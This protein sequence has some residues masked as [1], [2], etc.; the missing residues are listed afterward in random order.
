MSHRGLL[1]LLVLA[2]A[3]AS[4]AQTSTATLQG[5]VT[6][7]SGA[8][9]PGG[10]ILI[11]NVNTGTT[12]E[13]ASQSDGTYVVPFLL[14]GDYSLNV[15]KQGFRRFSQDRIR[16]NVGQTAVVDVRLV[17]GDIATTVEVSA[18]AAPLQTADSTVQTSISN[19]SITDLPLNGRLVLNLVA[20]VPG[21][22]TG[23]SSA[24]GQNDNYTPMI[25]G[26]RMMTS[27]AF[28][29][30]APLSVADPTG[31]ARV[32]GGLPPSPDAVEE[33]TVQVNGL[34]AE[35]GRSG[36]GV[37]NI[38][39]RAGTNDLHGTARYFHRNSVFDANNFFANRNSV[40]LA[41]F[42]RHQYGFSVGGPVHIP[43]VYSGRNRTF[44]FVDDEFT[45]ERSPRDVTTTL[46][47]DPWKQ[48]DFSGLLNFRGAPITIFD[49][50]T[51]RQTASGVWTRE[52]FPGNR[53]PVSRI[54]PISAK[55]I[56]YWPSPNRPSSNQFIP[57]N[58]WFNS[59][60][61]VVN[62]SNLTV[63]AD[64]NFTGSWRTYV[65]YN[66]SRYT[67]DPLQLVGGGPADSSS[68]NIRP[69]QNAVWDNTFILNPSTTMNVRLNGT[70]WQY[71]LYPTTMGFDSNSL[72]FPSYLRQE[73]LA[74]WPHFPGIGVSGV[75]GRGGGGG[76]DWFSNSVNLAGSV[77]K[78]RGRHTIKTG[79]EYRKFFLNFY[80]PG[81]PNGNFSFSD[82]WTRG[83][84]LSF[85][86][87][88]GFGFAT[89]LLGTP[90]GGSQNTVPK[91]ALASSYWAGFIQDDIRV[92]SKLTLNLGL[93][94]DMDT[95]RTE[96]YNRMSYYDLSA[97]S[98]IASQ[99][100][101]FPNLVGV[102]RYVDENNRRQTPSITDQ[103]AP[104]F[105]FAYQVNTK[106]VVRGGYAIMYDASPMQ[107]ANHNAG[108]EGFRLSNSMITTL[109]GG[110]TPAGTLS[111]PFPF[112]FLSPGRDPSF[113]LGFD[114]GDS[115]IP[116]W[117][118]PMVQQWN[119]NIQ[120]ELPGQMVV[121]VAYIANAGHQLQNG[122]TTPYNQLTTNYL[123]LGPQLRQQVPNPFYGVI[124]DQRS[125][126]SRPTVEYGQLLR[127][128]PQLTGLNLQWRP[129]GNSIY[130]AATIRAERRFSN[131]FAFMLAYTG[132][133]LISDSEASGFFTS[134]GQ[135]AAQDT[136][137][138]RAER[139]VSVEDIAHRV[140][141][142]GDYQLP[143]GRGKSLLSRS[144][145]IVQALIGNWQLNGIYTLQSGQ[146][147]N[148]LQPTNQMGI[149][150][151]RQRPSNNG[152]PASYTSG[153]TNDR[154][155]QWFD[156][157][158]FSI[159]PAF[160]L[161]TAPRTLT[162]V[163][164]PGRNNVDAS[165]FK[166]F[167]IL[168]DGRL[169]AQFRVEA[170]NAFN[171]AQFNRANATIGIAATGNITSVAVNP[172]QL[173]LGLKLIF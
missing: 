117:R 165:I 131:G 79:M 159:T 173:Q 36:G 64:H 59:G 89:F 127:P 154:I 16:L 33:F 38:A 90:T 160:Q 23:V 41:S 81:N 44:F 170:F 3:G 162:N 43:G 118:S 83:N 2:L 65:R 17:I 57:Q 106:T 67:I 22:Y 73:S 29:D 39:T 151:A 138:R 109:D 97:P 63:R 161:G 72:G 163:R 31:G 10:K 75:A 167:P 34:P 95:V 122:D 150:N 124:T 146:P 96:R 169:N 48:G 78:I 168:R 68:D 137:N 92:T 98:P 141:V 120:R 145:T 107:V 18:S 27:E 116:S 133:K 25:G 76:L 119:L 114:I 40:P 82:L 47:I 115:W 105:G 61:Q 70:R 80:Q 108:F 130:H 45:S 112:G 155:T 148:I 86:D 46:P 42:K 30:G 140:V 113:G 102:M 93:R 55:L 19:K 172:R 54:N 32:M 103:I 99:V 128:H 158:N 15:E 132:G 156:P 66:R 94:W 142:S 143:F 58:N 49:P 53:I 69:R 88:Q 71:S 14:P 7:D 149:Y 129:G 100:S 111:D 74:N 1:P 12:R 52:P 13:M 20:T 152:Q 11:T 62:T 139:A 135:S 144:N 8:A 85:S 21:V 26:A 164:H 157:S 28:V 4:W 56:P 35:Y 153:N 37:L 136:F 77:T 6:D 9:V 5:T 51:T 104:R 121:E 24:S 87:T 171:K 91:V 60:T 126:L 84:P 134:G 125:I 101:A 166:T 147:I 50:D 123:S 110:L